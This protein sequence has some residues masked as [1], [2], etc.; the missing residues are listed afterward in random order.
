MIVNRNLPAVCTPPQSK[1]NTQATNIPSITFSLIISPALVDRLEEENAALYFSNE[2]A[3]K[4]SYFVFL[5]QICF[6][7]KIIER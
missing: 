7:T 6:L 4:F 1:N 2:N 3:F 5:S